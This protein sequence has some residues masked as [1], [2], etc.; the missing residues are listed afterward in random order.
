VSGSVRALGVQ[1]KVAEGVYRSWKSGEM[2][3]A[4]SSTFA[5]GIA[6]TGAVELAFGVIQE[7]VDETPL[8]TETQMLRGIRGMIRHQ[9]I[10]LEAAAA[11]PADAVKK[12]RNGFSAGTFAPMV[13]GRTVDEATGKK[14][15]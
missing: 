6:T 2:M 7:H 11:A 3:D 10:L 1:A 5:G 9:A 8:M 15:T 12:H 14:A 13:T 4:P